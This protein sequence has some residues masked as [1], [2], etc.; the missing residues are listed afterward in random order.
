MQAMFDQHIA[1]IVEGRA[2]SVFLART[3]TVSMVWMDFF[4]VY[5]QLQADYTEV[6]IKNAATPP[7]A[8]EDRKKVTSIKVDIVLEA[9]T[10]DEAEARMDVLLLEYQRLID[11]AGGGT[12]ELK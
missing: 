12:I 7:E 11:A 3:L 8:D 6:Y 1:P 5:R 10:M 2:K 4:P 9:P